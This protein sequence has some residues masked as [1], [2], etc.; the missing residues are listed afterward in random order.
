MRRLSIPVD[1]KLYNEFDQKVP[2]GIKSSFMR[3]LIRIS[4]TASPEMMWAIATSEK[5]PERYG[6]AELSL[7]TSTPVEGPAVAAND[8]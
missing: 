8:K 7:P 5:S 6:I 2:D 1:N 3:N 4:M